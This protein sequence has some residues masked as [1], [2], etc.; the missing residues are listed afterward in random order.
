MSVECLFLGYLG[1][2]WFAR[3]EMLLFGATDSGGFSAAR[4]AK[5]AQI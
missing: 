3:A 2:S 5:E 1:L 4:K